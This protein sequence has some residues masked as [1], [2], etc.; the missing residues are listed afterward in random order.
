MQSEVFL[1]FCEKYP[2]PEKKFI[3]A[4]GAEDYVDSRIIFRAKDGRELGPQ[5]YLQEFERFVRENPGHIEALEILLKRP[6]EFD[7][8]QLKALRE[9]LATQ[10]DNLVDKFNEKN[11]RRAYNQELADII[12]I[13]RYAVRGGEL[14]TGERRVDKAMMKIKS[15]RSFTEE[16]IKWLDLI[17]RHLIENLL[18]EKEDIETLPIFTREGVSWKKLNKVFDGRLE[19]IIHEINEAIAA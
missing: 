10:P 18:M 5:D 4:N 8:K 14:L 3:R 6:K 13:I 17:R 11:L 12:S 7:T 9:K 16:Q 19:T 1:D 15:N 2:R